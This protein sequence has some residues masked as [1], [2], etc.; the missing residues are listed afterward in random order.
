MR[1][2]APWF[3]VAAC[4]LAACSSTPSA[5]APASGSSTARAPALHATATDGRDVDIDAA[6]K[7]GRTVVLVFWQT[8]C[9]SCLA[10][11]PQLAAASRAHPD[12]LL[13][14]GV[15]PGPDGTVD[16]EELARLVK[17]FDLPYAQ[18]R[19]RDLSWSRAFD[20]RGTPTLIALRADGSAGW[21]DRRPPADWSALH[22]ELRSR[23]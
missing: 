6:L 8:W 17:R 16:E 7:S 12:E 15:V 13:F 18:I 4:A 5:P 11:A 20:V 9:A 14:V 10:E 22:G 23:R 1:D 3:L 2:F 19:D 21:R